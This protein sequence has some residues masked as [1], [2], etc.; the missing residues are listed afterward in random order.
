MSETQ[1]TRLL[2]FLQTHPAASSLEIQSALVIT[3]CTGRL[4]DLRLMGE[5][6]GFEVVKEKR[7]DGRDGYSVRWLPK[8]TTLDLAS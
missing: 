7:S 1:T 6:E 4:S 2:H 5:R 8:Q 3:N